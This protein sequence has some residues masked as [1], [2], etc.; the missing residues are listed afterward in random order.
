MSK[1]AREIRQHMY[2]FTVNGTGEPVAHFRFGEDFIGFQGHFPGQKV[3]PGVCQIQC[4]QAVLEAWKG[5]TVRLREIV[6]AKYVLPVM[7]DEEIS[8]SCLDIKEGADWVSLRAIIT[9]GEEKI[10]DFRLK[11]TVATPEPT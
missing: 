9:R 2:G 5:T 1:V 11:V 10:S 6:S 3:L 8:C 7:P 4:V